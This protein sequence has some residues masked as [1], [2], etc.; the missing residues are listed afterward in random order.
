[1][2]QI[3]IPSN[4]QIKIPAT[5]SRSTVLSS[6]C[7]VQIKFSDTVFRS[8]HGQALSASPHITFA[9]PASMQPR[10]PDGLLRKGQAVQT[11]TTG[12][13]NWHEPRKD[14][15]ADRKKKATPCRDVKVTGNSAA[16]RLINS[17]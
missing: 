15:E 7:K 4:F 1:M 9:I 6:R 10:R 17:T 16:W 3:R 11:G 13:P 8:R 14:N 2:F 5:C 12:E